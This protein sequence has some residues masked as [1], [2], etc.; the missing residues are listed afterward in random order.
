MPRRSAGEGPVIRKDRRDYDASG[1]ST[2]RHPAMQ[3]RPDPARRQ[4]GPARRQPGNRGRGRADRPCACVCRQRGPA[5]PGQGEP[6]IF[7]S[8]RRRRRPV[9]PRGARLDPGAGRAVRAAPATGI[10]PSGFPPGPGLSAMRTAPLTPGELAHIP[11]FVDK[12]TRIGLSTTPVDHV[13]AERAL[14]RLYA[15]SGLAEPAVVWAPCPMTAM[16]SAIVYTAIRVTGRE[17]EAGDKQA[18]AAI[19]ERIIH[20]AL[21]AI[22]PAEAHRRMQLA[23]E[24]TVASALRLGIG[25]SSGFDAVFAIYDW[26]RAGLDRVSETAL[27]P[28]LRKRLRALLFEPVRTGVSSL[29]GLGGPAL[30][31]V[32]GGG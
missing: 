2:G 28:A 16:L 9:A 5:V 31:A 17:D 29:R 6:E 22:I 26:R 32:G 10:C 27:A 19:V 11:E 18:L 23:V 14:C 20:F 24:R 21:I 1:I 25:N 15:A 12:W 7:S 8:C 4:A 30:D 3:G 13:E